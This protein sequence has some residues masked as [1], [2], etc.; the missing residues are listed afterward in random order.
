MGFDTVALLSL[1][2]YGLSASCVAVLAVV[3]NLKQKSAKTTTFTKKVRI[4]LSWCTTIIYYTTRKLYIIGDM[5]F[6]RY[7]FKWYF[8]EISLQLAELEMRFSI[9]FLKSP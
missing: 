8:P 5:A 4:L 6:S 7:C 2:R 1:L 3:W 9:V